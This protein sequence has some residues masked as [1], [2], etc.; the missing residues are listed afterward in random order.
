M[1]HKLRMFLEAGT[2]SELDRNFVVWPDDFV[3]G[4]A[5]TISLKAN[6]ISSARFSGGKITRCWLEYLQ[7]KG[8]ITRLRQLLDL[9]VPPLNTGEQ[10]EIGTTTWAPSTEGKGWFR[11]QVEADDG[12][13]IE[14][15]REIRG[16]DE[17][18]KGDV[19]YQGF[20]VINRESLLI[21]EELHKLREILTK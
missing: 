21:A 10:Q 19:Y 8:V 17:L 6:N 12:K 1:V 2:D 20:Y 9:R 15:Y 18:L 3:R 5:Y 7:T 16:K 13:P 14:Y 4:E 11:I